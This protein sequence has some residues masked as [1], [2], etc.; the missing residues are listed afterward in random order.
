MPPMVATPVDAVIPPRRAI[1]APDR[2]APRAQEHHVGVPAGEAEPAV[3]RLRRARC[4]SRRR[5]SPAR[6]RGRAGAAGPATVSARPR[7]R[8]CCVGVDADDVHL[9][10]RRARA[11]M[12]VRRS[13]RRRRAPS[14]SGSRPAGS[15]SGS[16]SSSAS[17]NPR[18]EP[19]LGHPRRA[20]PPSVQRALLG[21][22][23]ERARRSA[24]ARPRRPRPG[25]KVRSRTPGGQRRLRQRHAQR[26]AQ[27]LQPAHLGE[28][29]RRA[30]ARAPP[31]WSPCAQ[32]RSRCAGRRPASAASTSS[33][34]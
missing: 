5:A 20:G 11:A 10:D 8:P 25:R 3:D 9:A 14:S 29:Q 30:P 17:R 21:V 28:A 18:V 1:R 27:L 12:I 26:A 19:V 16:P 2:S 15:P 31:G 13:C 22:V 4:R 7:P 24:P 23:R 34:P 32:S 33:R 6:A